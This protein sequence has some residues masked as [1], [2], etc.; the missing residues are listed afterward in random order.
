MNRYELVVPG[1]LLGL[2]AGCAQ[3]EPEAPG[4][5]NP[6]MVDQ[7]RAEAEQLAVENAPPSQSK[8]GPVDEDA[9]EEFQETE[10]GLKYRIRRKSNRRKPTTEDTVV[11]YYRGRLDDGTIFDASYPRKKPDQFQV[12][13]VI[14]GWIEGL[15]LIGVGGMIELEVP[16]DLAY[17]EAGRGSSIP[18]NATLHF[19]IE[20]IEIIERQ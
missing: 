13:G 16:S 4:G 18:P 6:L 20:L 12:R 15:Q 7:I 10:T 5:L 8:P 3:E 9:P 11:V 14:A 1:L 19:L 17:G 2:L